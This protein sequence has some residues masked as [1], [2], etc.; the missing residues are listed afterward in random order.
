[1][2]NITGTPFLPEVTDQI[3]KR[4]EFLGEN[5]KQDKHIIWQ[6]NKSAFLR[7]ASSVNI[8]DEFSVNGRKFSN[9]NDAYDNAKNEVSNTGSVSI[10]YLE[11]PAT[12]ILEDRNLP[13]SLTE[14]ILS[15][16]YKGSLDLLPCTPK[17]QKGFVF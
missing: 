5:P 14:I 6:N 4:Q 16:T 12:Q 3:N 1:M 2:G 9:I 13:K 10:T 11:T 15:Q 7:L 17:F 8:E